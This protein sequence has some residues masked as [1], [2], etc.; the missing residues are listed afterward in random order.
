MKKQ[1]LQIAKQLKALI[2]NGTVSKVIKE[3]EEGN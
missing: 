3:T 1:A 2:K